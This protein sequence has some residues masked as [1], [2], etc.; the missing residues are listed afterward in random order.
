M[1]LSAGPI[2]FANKG[3]A[4]LLLINRNREKVGELRYTLSDEQMKT[5][6]DALAEGR[7]IP[8]SS[9]TQATTPVKT[10]P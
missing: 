8:A 3:T 5:A 9:Q 7:P 4:L 10:A 2:Y 6:L 1:D